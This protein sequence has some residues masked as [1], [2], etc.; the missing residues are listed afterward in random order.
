MKKYIGIAMIVAMFVTFFVFIASVGGI[1]AALEVFI[2]SFVGCVWFF[3]A[4][5]LI[6]SGEN[7][8]STDPV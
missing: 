8:N 2:Y 4:L 7:G 5:H 1:K 3:T 6:E